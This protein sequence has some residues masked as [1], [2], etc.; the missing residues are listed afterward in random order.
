[1]LA[2]FEPGDTP[3]PWLG[4][5]RRLGPQSELSAQDHHFPVKGSTIKPSYSSSPVV[6]IENQSLLYDI[7]RILRHAKKLPEK[8]ASFYKDLN[9]YYYLLPHLALGSKPIPFDKGENPRDSENYYVSKVVRG[10]ISL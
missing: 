6:W 9:R 1:M 5:L 8:V 3:V 10:S 7:Q 4:N 2:L